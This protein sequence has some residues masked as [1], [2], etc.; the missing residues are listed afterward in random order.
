MRWML[1]LAAIG[2]CAWTNQATVDAERRAAADREIAER[3]NA[4]ARAQAAEQQRQ[5]A[6]FDRVCQAAMADPAQDVTRAA[7]INFYAQERA[8]EIER[9]RA[10][11]ENSERQMR[12]EQ[13]AAERRRAAWA[14]VARA[15]ADSPPPSPPPPPAYTPPKEMHCRPSALHKGL[16]CTEY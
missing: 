7:C 9:Q 5:R 13:E 12:A 4:A 10:D 8:A 15:L 16:D 14:G 11:R 2:G 6:E 1:L 3:Q